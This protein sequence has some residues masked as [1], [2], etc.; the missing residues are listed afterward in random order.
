MNCRSEFK[1]VAAT[2]L[3]RIHTPVSYAVDSQPTCDGER[4]R[5][6]ARY[7]YQPEVHSPLRAFCRG[8]RLLSVAAEYADFSIP[9]R[10]RHHGSPAIV[11]ANRSRR[12][13]IRKKGVNS[14]QKVFSAMGSHAPGAYHLMTS[15]AWNS[16]QLQCP[17]SVPHTPLA[18]IKFPRC[19]TSPGPLSKTMCYRRFFGSSQYTRRRLSFKNT[20]GNL[21]SRSHAGVTAL[22]D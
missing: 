12:F 16:P 4:G 20:C 11:G 7:Q 10:S 21:A 17:K 3:Q 6:D 15:F 22:R 5:S 2:Q 9:P 1:D 19:D 8:P 14:K 18:S 13:F